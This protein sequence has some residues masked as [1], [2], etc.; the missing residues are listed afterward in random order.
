MDVCLIQVPY[1]L[2]D[3]RHPSRDGPARLLEAGGADLLGAQGIA[4]SVES[5][6]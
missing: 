6:P 5:R 4:V 2:D 1:H 3:D